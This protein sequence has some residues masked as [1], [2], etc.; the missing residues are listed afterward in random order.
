M[1]GL[2]FCHSLGV[3]HRDLKLENLLLH[4][5]TQ[6]L[7]ICDFGF[8]KQA[9]PEEQQLTKCGSPYYAAPELL[10]GKGHEYKGVEA[11]IWSAGVILYAF[12]T[13][14]LPFQSPNCKQMFHSIRQG[15]FEIPESVPPLCAALINRI[16]K[17]DPKERPTATQVLQDPWLQAACDPP[18]V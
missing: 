1:C 7:K 15:D 13:C 14:K 9:G 8:A 2:Q 6:T 3:C 16:L 5:N 12:I 11:D 10:L 17:V 4:G 18:V